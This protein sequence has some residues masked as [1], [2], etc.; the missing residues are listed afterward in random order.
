M[1]CAVINTVAIANYSAFMY[2]VLWPS[3]EF[4]RQTFATL[5]LPGFNVVAA[6]LLGV[7]L[8]VSLMAMIR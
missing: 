4:V 6:S 1:V 8:R 5:T 2:V 3:D 7:S